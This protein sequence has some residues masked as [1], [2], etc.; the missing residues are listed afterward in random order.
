[1][2]YKDSLYIVPATSPT[3]PS[4]PKYDFVRLKTMNDNIQN[5]LIYM[6]NKHQSDM[7][8]MTDSITAILQKLTDGISKTDKYGEKLTEISFKLSNHEER[9][10]K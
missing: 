3:S 10:E 7:R 8:T 9:L 2:T 6:N 4:L 1:M 5:Y